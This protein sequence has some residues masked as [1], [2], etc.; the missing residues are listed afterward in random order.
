MHYVYVFKLHKNRQ[1]TIFHSNSKLMDKDVKQSFLAM[2]ERNI[3]NIKTINKIK[4]FIFN[5][6]YLYISDKHKFAT[7]V[8]H[9]DV[10][11]YKFGIAFLIIPHR[12]DKPAF[13]HDGKKQYYMDGKEITDK[14][15]FIK[16]KLKHA[17]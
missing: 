13:Y 1:K 15:Y 5:I 16:R 2:Q 8:I 14:F 7:I 17:N 6:K 9:Y 11:G 4:Y 3:L 12:I 10:G